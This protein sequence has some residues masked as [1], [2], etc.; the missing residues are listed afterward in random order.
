MS[1]NMC[2]DCG[3]SKLV[4]QYDRGQV[5]CINCGLVVD[6]VIDLGPETR[7]YDSDESNARARSGAPVTS[8]RPDLGLSTKISTS[9]TDAKGQ[10][11][12]PSMINR[13]RRL[14]WLNSR[15]NK[16]E[17]R[18]L[19][20]ALRILK[21]VGA[22]FDLSQDILETASLYYRKALKAR[23]IRGRSI[24]SMITA[25]M[26]LATRSHGLPLTIKD[27]EEKSEVDR[28]LIARCFR[29]YVKDLNVQVAS[30]DA[31]KIIA[32]I[33]AGLELT[34]ATQNKA[35]MILRE[36]KAA[37]LT[38]GK[39]PVS[40]SAACVYIASIQTGERRTQQQVAEISNTTPVTLRN[41]FKEIV[42]MLEYS[43]IN[44]KRGAA[45]TPVYFSTPWQKR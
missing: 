33:S 11:I 27:L 28:K 14:R 45:A 26:Y 35:L 4:S 37:K 31:S 25:A 43:D 20:I 3:G 44:I 18:N 9:R 29:V 1:I 39:S 2:P 7:C 8:L 41:R 40:I 15:T 17:I 22:N 23:L 13:M 24:R 21:Q 42:K 30:L 16:S 32:K 19:R 34:P 10:R 36:A 6:Q 38:M 5:V 12:A